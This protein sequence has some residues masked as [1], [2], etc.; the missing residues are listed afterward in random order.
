MREH[1]KVEI[2]NKLDGTLLLSFD[3]PHF[4]LS[5]YRL[6]VHGFEEIFVLDLRDQITI[7]RNPGR[8]CKVELCGNKIVATSDEDNTM[9]VWDFT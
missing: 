5:E 8:Y 1:S 6:V 4:I 7:F 2:R 3:A 9:H